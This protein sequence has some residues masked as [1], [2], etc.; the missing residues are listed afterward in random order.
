VSSRSAALLLPG[1]LSV[2]AAAATHGRLLL[3]LLHSCCAGLPAELP[4]RLLEAPLGGLL[5]CCGL[6]VLLLLLSP[7]PSLALLLFAA[8]HLRAAGLPLVC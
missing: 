8:E 6:F 1:A 5:G 3:L 7:T 4:C 2:T